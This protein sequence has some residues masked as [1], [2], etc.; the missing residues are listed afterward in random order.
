MSDINVTLTSAEVKATLTSTVI[1]VT[2][3]N[4]YE[5]ILPDNV[6]QDSEY[7]H[8]DNN[9]TTDEKTKLSSI[10]EN[11]EVNVNADWNATDG[12]GQILNKPST[13]P[14]DSHTHS[15]I[16]NATENNAKVEVL[17]TGTKVSRNIA[18]ANPALSVDNVLGT[19][20][21][22]EFKQGGS[23]VG[24]VD[25]NGTIGG[26]VEQTVANKNKYLPLLK[27]ILGNDIAKRF[28]YYWNGSAYVAH[29]AYGFGYYALQTNTGVNSNGFGGYAL[30]SNTGNYSN[31]FG[32]YALQSNTG[33]NSN[34]FGY[35]A[36][37]TNTGAYS[38]G[39]GHYALQ[40][41]TGVNSNGFGG[42]A[43]Q[44][45]T[46]NYSSGFGG[47]A[48]QSN[49]GNYSSGFGYYALQSNT[50][51]N[52]NGFGYYALRYNKGANNTAVGQLA[53][54]IENAT[55]NAYT[56]T[57]CLGAYT[58]PNKSNQVV[59]GSANVDTVKMGGTYRTPAS[60][61]DTG[62]KGETCYDS[63]YFYVC[64][65]TDIWKRI[66]METW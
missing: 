4:G 29:E 3:T 21:I 14:P 53:N 25:K 54:G 32:Y 62:V 42:Y 51:V 22:Q 57:T 34:G 30:Q 60:S 43:L 44:S 39:F 20:N 52:S 18:D 13:F 1:S 15:S 5:Y 63:N 26:G 56:N 17:D 47:Y 40:Y 9:Y 11:A 12:D 33:V 16:V 48:L 36:L 10:A 31:G 27:D 38:N 37:Q 19:S 35:C 23:L 59:L 61:T 7:V 45:N 49:T 50:G 28:T 2:I 66:P 46:G 65:A 41:N 8:T 64:I 6:V 58:V 24:F 55:I